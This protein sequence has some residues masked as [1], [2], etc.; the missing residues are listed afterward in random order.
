LPLSPDR[1]VWHDAE[2]TRR[3]FLGLAVDLG[4]TTVAGYLYDLTTGERLG[5]AS[6][7]NRQATFGADVVSRISQ[8][9]R[10][11][12]PERLQSAIAVTVA[13]VARTA[14]AGAG[15]NPADI[16]TVLAVGNSVMH[17]LFLGLDPTGLGRAPFCATVQEPLT[18]P[19]AAIPGLGVNEQ[20]SVSLLPLIGGYLGADTTAMI[21]STGLHRASEVRLAIDIGTNG[22]IV[23][24]SRDG[25]WACSAAAGPAFE[26]ASLSA[27]MRAG[28]GAIDKVRIGAAVEISVLGGGKPR[29]LCGSGVVATVAEMLQAGILMPGGRFAGL[30]SL[31]RT[32][33][34][35]LAARFTQVPLVEP[36]QEKGTGAGPGLEVAFILVPAGATADGAPILLRQTDV[37]AVQLAK[38]AIATAIHFVLEVSGIKPRDL[39]EILLAGAFGSHIRS[40]D[41]RRIGLLPDFPGVPIRPVGNAAG[42]GASM[43]LLSRQSWAE[44]ATIPGRVVQVSLTSRPDFG[45]VFTAGLNF[46]D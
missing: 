3:P 1:R 28:P 5:R 16:Y 20:A 22:E 30:E 26:G 6:A 42:A 39:A 15:V 8:V 41:A 21:L 14:C 18:V 10:D 27:G 12:R 7:L 44:A 33:R 46:P 23:V 35:E 38:G 43:C 34:A 13:E 32:G 36:S 9:L 4:T 11:G 45:K 37:R 29:G 19:A 17:H 25:L 24:G 40:A 2:E 31:R